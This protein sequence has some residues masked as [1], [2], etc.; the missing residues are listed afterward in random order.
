MA[1]FEIYIPANLS[2]QDYI[3]IIQTARVWADGYDKKDLAR[4]SATLAPE[5][6]V[7]YTSVVPAW[8]EKRYTCH[9]FATEWLSPEHLGNKALATQHLLGQPYIKSVSEAE[10]VV[11][12]QQ[13]ASHGRWE[14]E[15]S[16]SGQ[17]GKKRM[18]VETS[19]GRSWM[20]HKFV[21]IEGRWKIARI[22]PELRYDTG[23]FMRIR[24]PEG[25]A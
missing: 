2:F 20:E 17:S 3:A 24:R 21:R 5:V 4:L 9:E 22:T 18:I 13:L 25:A 16:V 14:D 7:D 1:E 23:D 11:Q 15:S 6:I 10:I 19:D 8:G 12:W